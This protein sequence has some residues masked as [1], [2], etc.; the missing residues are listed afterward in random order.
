M[1]TFIGVRL[2]MKHGVIKRRYELYFGM[3]CGFLLIRLV[4]SACQE[5]RVLGFLLWELGGDRV[6]EQFRESDLITFFHHSKRN[7]SQI[8]KLLP[9]NSCFVCLNLYL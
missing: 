4:I 6:K 3:K 7:N 5:L 1:K 9:R 8:Y 2:S